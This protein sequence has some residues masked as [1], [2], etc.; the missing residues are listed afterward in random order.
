MFLNVSNVGVNADLLYS[1]GAHLTKNIVKLVGK[2]VG[3]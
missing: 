3:L 1:R 2:K